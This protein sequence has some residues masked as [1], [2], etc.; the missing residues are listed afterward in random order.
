MNAVLIF[1]VG[2]T[3]LQLKQMMFDTLKKNLSFY[4]MMFDSRKLPNE[5]FRI[6]ISKIKK[7]HSPGFSS[8]FTIPITFKGY[9]KCKMWI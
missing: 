1:K 9:E 4:L 7:N 5:L 6:K 2:F 8:Y 3:N